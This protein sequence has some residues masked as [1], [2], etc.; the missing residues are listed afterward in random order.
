MF[1]HIRWHC[2]GNVPGDRKAL[3]Q[4]GAGATAESGSRWDSRHDIWQQISAAIFQVRP[5]R[6]SVTAV[7]YRP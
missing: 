6:A 5:A 1:I 7:G 3:N 4:S 2:Q